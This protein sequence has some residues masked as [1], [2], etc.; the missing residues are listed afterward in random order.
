MPVVLFVGNPYW[1]K[2]VHLIRYSP[3]RF[4]VRMTPCPFF[5]GE[6]IGDSDEILLA[7]PRHPFGDD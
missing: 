1:G 7:L 4:E 6:E 3:V 2:L 5:Q